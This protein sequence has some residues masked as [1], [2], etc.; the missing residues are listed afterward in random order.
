MTPQQAR[1]LGLVLELCAPD[2]AASS[3]I[4]RAMS[5][6]ERGSNP[7]DAD[8]TML[9]RRQMA[10]P[11]E[12]P[13]DESKPWPPPDEVDRCLRW[14]FWDGEWA[15]RTVEKNSGAPWLASDSRERWLPMPAPPRQPEMSPHANEFCGDMPWPTALAAR[16][17]HRES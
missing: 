12:A 1:Y 6:I 2:R 7:G 15:W 11:G 9:E 16:R 3:L 10:T 13:Q 5:L 14:S 8:W 4:H 17:N